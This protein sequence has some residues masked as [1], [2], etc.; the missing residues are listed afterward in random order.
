MLIKLHFNIMQFPGQGLGCEVKCFRTCLAD[1][2]SFPMSPVSRVGLSRNQ[3]A[4]VA[5]PIAMPFRMLTRVGPRN[6]Y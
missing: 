6:M 5:E 4:K 2:M 3:T 1:D